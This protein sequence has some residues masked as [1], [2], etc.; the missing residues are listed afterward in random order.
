MHEPRVVYQRRARWILVGLAG[1]M[2]LVVLSGIVAGDTDAGPSL[3]QQIVCA[4]SAAILVV[5]MIQ[6]SRLAV[7]LTPEHVQVRN[8]FRS[9]RLRWGDIEAVEEPTLY[10]TWR[11]AG[12]RLRATG[13][14]LISATAF[15]RGL[16]DSPNVGAEVV[17][18]I[19]AR[20]A[21]ADTGSSEH[22]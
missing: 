5:V 9:Y 1:V 12:L 20:M 22:A 18:A 16:I 13:G 4:V 2:L 8:L 15:T 21:G 17:A 3:L 6:I 11:Q 14:H 10:G 7:V 19:R